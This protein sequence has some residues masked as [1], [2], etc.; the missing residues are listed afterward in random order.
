MTWGGWLLL[1]VAGGWALLATVVALAL[2]AGARVLAGDVAEAR[3]EDQADADEL[4][5]EEAADVLGVP[6]HDYHDPGRY[7]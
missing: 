5:W 6:V 1:A 2:L 3:R 7:T 4:G